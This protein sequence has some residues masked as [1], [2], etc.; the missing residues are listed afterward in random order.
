[1]AILSMADRQDLLLD[2]KVGEVRRK[3]LELAATIAQP[4]TEDL[5]T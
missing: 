4:P 1:M 5:D 2:R 3:V